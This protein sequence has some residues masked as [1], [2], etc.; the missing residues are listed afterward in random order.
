[1]GFA[2]LNARA[3][4]DGY[5][6]YSLV[7]GFFVASGWLAPSASGEKARVGALIRWVGIK[8]FQKG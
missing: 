7:V 1:M 2:L 8:M 3:N 4:H 6:F 5:S